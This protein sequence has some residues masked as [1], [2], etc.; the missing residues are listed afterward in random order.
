MNNAGDADTLAVVSGVAMGCAGC[1]IP[2]GP[3]RP[4]GPL[5]ARRVYFFKIKGGS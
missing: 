4:V 2:K 3:W 1:A 5:A